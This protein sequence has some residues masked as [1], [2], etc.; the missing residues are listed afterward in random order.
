MNNI[1]F[2]LVFKLNHDE[3]PEIY[4]DALYEAGC[5]DALVAVGTRGYIALDFNCGA[6]NPQQA[7]VKAYKKVLKAIPHA[8]LDRAEPYLLNVTELAYQFKFTKQNMRKYV[9]GEMAKIDVDFPAP[10]ISSKTSYWH[11]AEVAIWLTENTNI[12][13]NKSKV[14]T[15]ISVWGLNQAL[16]NRRYPDKKLTQSY[17]SM[18]ENVA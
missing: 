6:N 17:E 4:L 16:E 11:V 3:D 14:D 8:K 13:I 15:L 2:E 7:I 9:C 18:L 10:V 1:E 12:D 5:D